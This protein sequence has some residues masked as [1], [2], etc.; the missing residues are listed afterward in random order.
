MALVLK[1]RVKETTS[2]TGT[3]SV[4]LA[5][6]STGFQTFNSAIG[7][8]N[9]TYYCIAGQG[10]SE[11][12][13]GVGTLSASTTLARTTV[14]ASSNAGSLVTFSAGTKDV[15][16][17]YPA[18]RSVSMESGTVML[19]AQTAAPS[20]WTKLTV[21]NNYALRVVTGSAGNNDAGVG[22]TTAFASQGVSGTV[23]ST[24][25]STAQIPSH[26]HGFNVYT[27]GKNFGYAT[28]TSA[29]GPVASGT[30]AEGGG[31]SHDHSFTGT[32]INLAVNYV[33]VIQASKD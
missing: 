11:W 18:G 4:T 30:A 20:G 10:T 14:L 15:F 17:S 13:V 24:T 27:A 16:C 12:E 25:L 22:F 21:R 2:T 29:S 26:A 31:G 5:G 3:G 19:F 28:G 6:A 8:G 23:G 1:D 32:A 9:T 7:V 33:D